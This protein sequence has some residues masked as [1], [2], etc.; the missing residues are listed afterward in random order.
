M[1]VSSI[2]ARPIWRCGSRRIRRLDERTAGHARCNHRSAPGTTSKGVFA[3][4]DPYVI[5]RPL[6]IT[7]LGAG[8]A[9]GEQ[10]RP[11]PQSAWF[12]AMLAPAIL[13]L[14]SGCAP[15]ASDPVSYGR[16]TF[17]TNATSRG[18][19]SMFSQV[20]EAAHVKAA[21]HCAGMDKAMRPVSQTVSGAQGW[22][23]GRKEISLALV[24]RCLP[25]GPA[26]EPTPQTPAPP[27]A[28]P[29]RG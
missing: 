13:G 1:T 26:S 11:A 6:R 7:A 4:T 12:A 21:D 9:H 29:E 15:T 17:M 16:D 18:G 19:Y 25:A 24:Y 2:R 22:S 8:D 10:R 14:V 23:W 28:P 20:H 3:M 27:P 5:R